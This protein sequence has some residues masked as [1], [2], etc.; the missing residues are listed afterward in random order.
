MRERDRAHEHRVVQ[1]AALAAGL[2]TREPSG[3]VRL[4][5]GTAQL[6]RFADQRAGDLP[7]RPRTDDQWHIEVAEELADARNYLVWAIQKLEPAYLAG[8]GDA[9]DR[10]ASSLRALVAV[11]QAWSALTG[12]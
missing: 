9:A 6:E 11:L 5:G 2:A 1:L 3:G 7:L 12:P 4:L 10:Y 8:D